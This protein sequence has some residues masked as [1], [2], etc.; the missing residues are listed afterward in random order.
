M[1]SRPRSIPEMNTLRIVLAD[2][3]LSQKTDVSEYKR[4]ELNGELEVE[5]LLNKEDSSKHNLFPIK[6]ID[7]SSLFSNHL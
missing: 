2:V 3:S 1:E 6:H 7:V 4:M 5:P